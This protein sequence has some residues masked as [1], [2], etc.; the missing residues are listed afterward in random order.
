VRDA[1][2]SLREFTFEESYLMWKKLMVVC[3]L[4]LWVGTGAIVEAKPPPSDVLG[5]RLGM[6]EEEVHE[7]LEKI[8]KQREEEE[9]GRREE[10]QEIWI[11][12][13]DRRLDYLL[14]RFGAEEKLVLITVVAR[15]NARLR[16]RDLGD[17]KS[18]RQA[19]D[20]KNYSYT[21]RVEAQGNA[22]AYGVVAR[23]S[24]AKYLT[25]YS[26]YRLAQRK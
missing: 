1:A 14:V 5:L 8:A 10:E 24:N 18:A 9:G 6:N 25:S 21:W 7:R 3:V 12:R 11:L 2:L 17:L 23:G 22:P 16:Y 15:R 19:T 26:L 13:N 4:L 20:G